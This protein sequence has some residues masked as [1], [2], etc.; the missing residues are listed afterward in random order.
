M[1]GTTA[2]TDGPES[3]PSTSR[4]L[5]RLPHEKLVEAVALRLGI[6]L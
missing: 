4:D 2:E 1:S 5:S 3:R 6:A